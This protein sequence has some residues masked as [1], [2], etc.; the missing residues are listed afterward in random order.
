MQNTNRNIEIQKA[1]TDVTN[2][3][4]PNLRNGIEF[5]RQD[6]RSYG[7]DMRLNAPLPNF[8]EELSYQ[9]R[10]IQSEVEAEL[11][12]RQTTDYVVERTWIEIRKDLENYNY[13]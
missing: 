3:N 13:N 1:K 10:G 5:I 7:V 4:A 2:Q 12:E 6:G 11:Q 8:E 9:P